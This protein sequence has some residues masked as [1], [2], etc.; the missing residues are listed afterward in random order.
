MPNPPPKKKRK[1]NIETD[2][3]KT[4]KLICQFCERSYSDQ[5]FGTLIE[6]KFS[7]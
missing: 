6:F 3:E 2:S 4:D 1:K 5:V 7:V